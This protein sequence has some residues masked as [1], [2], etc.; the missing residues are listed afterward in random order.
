M[1]HQRR[2]ESFTIFVSFATTL[3][4]QLG[5]PNLVSGPEGTDINFSRKRGLPKQL[6]CRLEALLIRSLSIL[7]THLPQA[8]MRRYHA[9][10]RQPWRNGAE[11]H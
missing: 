2:T 3:P 10:E 7:L 5:T 11:L 1:N 6:L 8:S 9:L 4:H